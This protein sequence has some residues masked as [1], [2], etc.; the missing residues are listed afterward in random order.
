LSLIHK[1]AA[2]K[3]KII[4]LTNIRQSKIKK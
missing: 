3:V 4:F 1:I 2:K